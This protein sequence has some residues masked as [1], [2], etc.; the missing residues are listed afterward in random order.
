ML[1][2]LSGEFWNGIMYDLANTDDCSSSMKYDVNMCGYNEFDDCTPIDGCG[3]APAAY[4]YFL[5]FSLLVQNW[6]L[7][8]VYYFAHSVCDII[9]STK[10]QLLV[11]HFK[12]SFVFINLFIGVVIDGFEVGRQDTYSRY[13]TKYHDRH[14]GIK[15]CSVVQCTTVQCKFHLLWTLSLRNRSK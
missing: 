9:A 3:S 8:C 12:V 7:L 5:T 10:L 6:K 11:F 13:T 2:Q 4:M 15:N 1:A 14:G